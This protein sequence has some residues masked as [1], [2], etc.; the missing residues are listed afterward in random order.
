MDAHGCSL[1]PRNAA[2]DTCPNI[3]PR[4]YIYM[5]HDG[6]CH[7]RT[8][9]IYLYSKYRSA[10]KKGPKEHTLTYI[11]RRVT[12]MLQPTSSTEESF[13]ASLGEATNHGVVGV[14]RPEESGP[15]TRAMLDDD[16]DDS[17]QV[18]KKQ[19]I[20]LLNSQT[21]RMN[22]PKRSVDTSGSQTPSIRTSL[23]HARG[24]IVAKEPR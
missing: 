18:K 7:K 24:G 13:Q 2:E 5:E 20:C 14:L 22:P 3:S 10:C 6:T 11:A 23:Q 19:T 9:V 15:I 21:T 1:Q 16:D 8:I 17:V 12:S 4:I